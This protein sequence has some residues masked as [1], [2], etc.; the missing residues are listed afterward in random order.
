MSQFCIE[1]RPRTHKGLR[2]FLNKHTN[3]IAWSNDSD[4]PLPGDYVF[5]TEEE[6]EQA[7]KSALLTAQFR[8]PEIFS[9]GGPTLEDWIAT[10]KCLEERIR[11]AQ[12]VANPF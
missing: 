4:K 5:G 7:R 3:R 9:Y 11:D 1:V 6:A 8:A 12:I 2:T 10:K